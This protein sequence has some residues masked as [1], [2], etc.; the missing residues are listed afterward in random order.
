[1]RP[2]VHDLELRFNAYL[3]VLPGLEEHWEFTVS[4]DKEAWSDGIW[5]S[6]DEGEYA[7][8]SSMQEIL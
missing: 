2:K 3:K 8:S 7:W 4:G 5:T 1:M 6:G